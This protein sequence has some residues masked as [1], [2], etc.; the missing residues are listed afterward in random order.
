M[1]PT[2]LETFGSQAREKIQSLLDQGE[3]FAVTTSPESRTYVRMVIERMFPTM[4]V[5]SNLEIARGMV[6]Q[7]LG[8]VSE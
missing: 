8:D 2:E 3:V 5:L 1:S 4:P 6:V 7:V